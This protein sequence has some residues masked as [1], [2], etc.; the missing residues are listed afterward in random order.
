MKVNSI[1]V[2][3]LILTACANAPQGSNRNQ[4]DDSLSFNLVGQL[5]FRYSA[6]DGKHQFK[7]CPDETCDIFQ[8]PLS[9]D[10]NVI[11]SFIAVY[12]C[13]GWGYDSPQFNKFCKSSEEKIKEAVQSL[14]D[15]R[16]SK[17]KPG[18]EV[19]CF[20]RNLAKDKGIEILSERSDEGKTCLTVYHI[21]DLLEKRAKPKFPAKT[22]CK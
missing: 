17:T 18:T 12:E 4:D 6:S 13:S 3:S 20:L 15:E 1:L 21:D 10:R 9:T 5:D 14:D 2:T 22:S 8:T 16:C 19:K 7:I 11:E